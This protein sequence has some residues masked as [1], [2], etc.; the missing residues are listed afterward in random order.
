[1][2]CVSGHLPLQSF[3]V[4]QLQKFSTGEPVSAYIQSIEEKVE[5]SS[6]YFSDLSL[7]EHQGILMLILAHWVTHKD[8]DYIKLFIQVL[9]YYLTAI[10]D[11]SCEN[12]VIS[13]LPTLSA[14]NT[15]DLTLNNNLQTHAVP[16][17][18][19]KSDEFA[20]VKALLLHYGIPAIPVC[21]MDTFTDSLKTWREC[22]HSS[23]SKV[24][25]MLTKF[26][27]ITED[28]HDNP[29]KKDKAKTAFDFSCH[30]LSII[31]DSK[32]WFRIFHVNKVSP[33]QFLTSDQIQSY[34]KTARAHHS[35]HNSKHKALVK[36]LTPKNITLACS[37]SRGLDTQEITL[38]LTQ[39]V[40]KKELTQNDIDGLKEMLALPWNLEDEDTSLL[41]K[42][43]EIIKSLAEKTVPYKYVLLNKVH[44][45]AEEI[46]S[47]RRILIVKDFAKSVKLS[48]QTNETV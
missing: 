47:M 35:F 36:E 30:I 5:T 7:S 18:R 17:Q 2:N 43:L 48:R 41:L 33:L 4:L 23:N 44:D 16:I 45:K 10:E 20:C 1:M 26:L 32:F 21:P 27:C 11:K 22:Q 46:A 39:L 24:S 9:P 40:A 13:Y 34:Y 42:Q 19:S 14:G 31:Q 25:R 6:S 3:H 12:F 37:I 15:V 28:W 8:S 29:V 38:M